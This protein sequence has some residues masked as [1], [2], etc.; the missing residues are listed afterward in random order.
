M[1]KA[2]LPF[3]SLAKTRLRAVLPTVRLILSS[4]RRRG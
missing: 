2:Y 3:G 4:G 1:L